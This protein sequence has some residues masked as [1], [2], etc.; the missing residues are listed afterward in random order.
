MSHNEFVSACLPR[1]A[2]YRRHELSCSL[3]PSGVAA[4]KRKW[5]PDLGFRFCAYEV[6]TPNEDVFVRHTTPRA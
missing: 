4:Q 3:L 5:L 2:G 1:L 6:S